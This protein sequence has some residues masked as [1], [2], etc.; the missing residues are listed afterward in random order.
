MRPVGTSVML[1]CVGW[2]RCTITG[3]GA[4]VA[5]GELRGTEAQAASDI[6]GVSPV[7]YATALSS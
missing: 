4:S 2:P 3:T 1:T 7:E 6:G 5:Q